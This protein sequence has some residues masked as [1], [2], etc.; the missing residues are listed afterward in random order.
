MTLEE[1]FWNKVDIPLNEK[2][3][4][5]HDKC[6]MW[7]STIY[8]NGYGQFSKNR[9]TNLAHRIAYLLENGEFDKTKCV[10][11][12]CDTKACVNPKHLWSGTLKDNSQDCKNKGRTARGDKNGARLYPE[13]ILRG[14]NHPARLHPEKMSHGDKNGS[15]IHPERLARGENNGFA[16]LTWEEV[17]KIRNSRGTQKE[18]A[19][20]Y[21]VS[22]VNISHIINN[23]T[24]KQK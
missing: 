2:G 4:P 16:K 24:W 23:K 22:Q 1:R 18:L 19:I 8:K 12:R 11:H 15:R 3:E 6:W 20:K 17:E 7:T 14:D 21:Q 5:D 13:R 10:L 9:K